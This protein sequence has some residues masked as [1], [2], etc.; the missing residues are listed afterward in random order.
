MCPSVRALRD[1]DPFLILSGRDH[2]WQSWAYPEGTALGIEA[3]IH[4]RPVLNNFRTETHDMECA[5]EL[6]SG[7]NPT[8]RGLTMLSTFIRTAVNSFVAV[9]C[10]MPAFAASYS[11]PLS[12]ADGNIYAIEKEGMSRKGYIVHA[13]QVVNLAS[14]KDGKVQSVRSLVE[15]NCR[16]R[17][18]RTMWVSEHPERDAG[19]APLNS[20]QVDNPEWVPLQAGS[21]TEKL[22]EFSCSHIMR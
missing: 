22:L 2:C 10:V 9:C 12:D 15:F 7:N 17:Q 20:G 3:A 14:P 11:P 21:L 16:F 13:W 4:A 18:S 1:A 5:G 19:G 6:N 8:H